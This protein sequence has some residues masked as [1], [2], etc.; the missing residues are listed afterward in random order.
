MVN[1]IEKENQ[2]NSMNNTI[3]IICSILSMLSGMI[4]VWLITRSKL[5][6]LNDRLI[7]TSADKDDALKTL[8]E[9]NQTVHDLTAKATTLE[10]TLAFEKESAE[11]KI[12]LL[13]QATEEL[14]MTFKGLSSDALKS[15]TKSFLELA[16]SMFDNYQEQSKKEFEHKE[17]SVE[18]LVNPLQE[19]LNKVTTQVE[20]LEK[21]RQKA[22][23]SLSEQVK[24]LAMTQE[25]LR[26]ETINLTKAL[27][28]PTVRG[29]WGEI[30]LKRVVEI[31]GMIPYCDFLEQHTQNTDDGRL[32]PDLIVKLPGNKNIIV[33]AKA[34]LKAY[35]DALDCNDENQ[36]SILLREHA[37]HLR[38]HTTK[39]SAKAY[40]EQFEATPEFVIMF[41][42]SET[43]F[44][45]ALEQ[46]HTI[47]EEGV[48]QR[49]IIASPTTLIALLRAV[50]YGWR[51]E[52]IAD[53]A[54][55]ISNLGKELYERLRNLTDHFMSVGRNLDRAVDSYNRAIGTLESRVLTSARRF[56]ELGSDSKEV[57]QFPSTIEKTSR[58]V[59]SPE[60][61]E[62][63][64]ANAD[65]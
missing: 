53:N 27:R 21:S 45:A 23:G 13:N 2:E 20:K 31:A 47:I 28:S 5:A 10:T 60:L 16:K 36:K 25:K 49:V 9:K 26:S 43:F 24:S 33:D 6:I 12:K 11:E 1:G 65:V 59:Q 29:R 57:I 55:A 41:L 7:R 54:Q 61:L 62:P 34:P 37:R 52:R 22:Y 40:W 63:P 17:K 64:V 44:S 56:T 46:D 14:R 30:Q 42:P 39:L 19:S 38:D 4:F 18:K 3:L 48:N 8:I 15:N 58:G 50:A 35:L 51:Q 32:R